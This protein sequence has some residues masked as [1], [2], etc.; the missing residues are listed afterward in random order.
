MKCTPFFSTLALSGILLISSCAKEQHQNPLSIADSAQKKHLISEL[1]FGEGDYQGEVDPEMYKCETAFALGDLSFFDLGISNH[2]RWGWVIPIENIGTFTY[3]IYAAAGQGDISKGSK[4][5]ELYVEYNGR[6][7]E[8]IF[9]TYDHFGL[10][11]THVYIS[12]ELPSKIAPGRYTDKHQNLDGAQIDKYSFI[13]NSDGST[14]LNPVDYGNEYPYD[15]EPTSSTIYIIAHATV[16]GDFGIEVDDPTTQSMVDL[17][18][19]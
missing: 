4:I 16:C 7:A 14:D 2:K 3:P 5:G 19:N 6:D 9:E 8:V 18:D 10:F 11:E 15:S 1:P 13:V 12:D 17:V